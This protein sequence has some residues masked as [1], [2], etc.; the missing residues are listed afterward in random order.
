MA[1]LNNITHK[2]GLAEPHSDNH[3]LASAELAI[4][5]VDASHQTAASGKL[6]YGE[7]TGDLDDLTGT[8][9]NVRTFGIGTKADSGTG[10]SGVPIGGNLYFK[11]GSN[12]TISQGVSGDVVT[13][14][15]TASGGSSANNS[16]ITLTAGD[17]LKTG[18]SFTTNASSN[19]EI[20]FD[21][22]VSDFAGA[23]LAD[24]G[25]E[26][27]TIDL[28]E[29]SEVTPASGD[30]FLTLDS[31]GSTEQLTTV[32]ALATLLAGSNLSASNGVLSATDTNT[33][34]ST[35]QVQD[36]AGGMFSSNTETLIT[37]TY[38]DGDGTIDLVVDNDLSNYDNSSSGFITST[39]TTEQVQDIVGAMF[40]S[41][42][43]TRI[44]AT[45]QDGDG[46]I[47]LAVDDMTANDNDDVSVANLKT[48]LAG[49]FGSNAVTIGDSND[50]VTIGGSLDLGDGNITNVG[51]IQLDSITGDGDTNTS[52]TFS[53]SD[54][55]TFNTSG[56]DIATFQ[57]DGDLQLSHDLEMS[58]DA[59]H[60]KFGSD[61]EI[62]LTHVADTGLTL[63]DSGG[64]PTL[65]FHDSNESVSSDG[66]NL[67]LTS[68]GTA[69]KI[70][71]SDGS[72][73][74]FLQTNGSGT[75][76][77]ASASG[78][79]TSPGGSGSVSGSNAQ[80]QF[81][82]GGSFGGDSQFFWDGTKL[83][84]EVSTDDT[85]ALKVK[86]TEDS[87]ADGPRIDLERSA[88][89]SG[90]VSDGDEIGRIRFNGDKT[91]GSLITYAALEGGI[92][93]NSDSTADGIMR[94]GIRRQGGYE[95]DFLN[96]GCSNTSGNRAV[97]AGTDNEVDLGTSSK[98]FNDVYA[99][100]YNGYN[101]SS[102][103]SGVTMS[104]Q[105]GN[106]TTATFAVTDGS[107]ASVNLTMAVSGGIVALADMQPSG[108][109]SDI[110]YKEN[111]E[112][113]SK[114][115]SFVESLPSSRTWDWKDSASEMRPKVNGK[116]SE[117][118][119][120]QE[121][122]S[123]GLSEYVTTIKSSEWNSIDD[124]VEDYKTVEYV[125][126]EKDILYSLVNS[127]KELSARVKELEAK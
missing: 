87:S 90:Q 79:S 96:I 51:D 53:G 80:I 85:A 58:H 124:S 46:T 33:Q 127:V 78:G 123:A 75:L 120:A 66:S 122:E 10:Q 92:V 104:D 67:I 74:Q 36:I 60:I 86:C 14:T 126:L 20:T 61:L 59:A 99:K 106:P 110:K 77:F 54:V 49:G 7:N 55:I 31:N 11:E 72:N 34:L 83:V 101:G 98:A 112:D 29:Y 102:F 21:I 73:G 95:A 82:D 45:Y 108:A 1:D 65:R 63:T 5:Q 42:T 50:V 64:S 119:V 6:Y 114:G 8:D 12:M 23:G 38:Q 93:D 24:G 94:V 71:T 56:N 111:L 3:G 88:G 70:P 17:G 47:D 37:A 105:A 76:S 113:Y 25:S 41:N 32:D 39:L 109:G 89:G 57:S 91:N 43:E 13:L 62:A 118:Y 44:T 27:L 15:F 84:I 121:L 9:I 116:S 100:D 52:I 26:N 16:T 97:F 35:E 81:N 48:R 125:K 22:D 68:G 117:G 107:G 40:S 69:F 28:S 115:L 30:A 4:K 18:G 2:T 19:S 103:D